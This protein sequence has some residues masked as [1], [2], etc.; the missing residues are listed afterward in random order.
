MKLLTH[1]MIT[2]SLL[3]LV[4][5]GAQKT[6]TTL[7]VSSG[8][9]IS[10][11]TYPG[12][13]VF[14]GNSTTGQKFSV[15]VGMIA[16]GANNQVEVVLDKGI[17]SFGA[18]GWA[19]GN[20]M[21]GVAEC[22]VLPSVN[23]DT[24][25]KV[26]N[27]DLNPTDCSLS[28]FGENLTGTTGLFKPLRLVTCGSFYT[29][30]STGLVLSSNDETFC[31]SN[32]NLA[33]DFKLHAKFARITVPAIIPGQTPGASPLTICVPLTDGK[34]VTA[35]T[36]PAKGLP[37][38]IELLESDC[39]D[40]N[41]KLMSS[42]TLLKGINATYSGFDHQ[43][44]PG[45]TPADDSTLYLL[46]TIS[47]RGISSLMSSLP[48]FKCDYANPLKPCIKIPSTTFDRYVQ[49]NQDIYIKDQAAGESCTDLGS[50]GSLDLNTADILSSVGTQVHCR[51]DNGK[52]FVRIDKSLFGTAGCTVSCNL[53]IN[54]GVSTT[55]LSVKVA[56][57][58]DLDAHNLVYRT[59]GFEN[60]L[61]P[62]PASPLVADQNNAIR[63]LESLTGK[64]DDLRQFGL[65]S[66]IREMFSPDAIG[67]LFWNLSATQM[68]NST[69]NVSFWED[70][71]Q[72]SYQVKSVAATSI[73]A[74]KIPPYLVSNLIPGTTSSASYFTHIITISRILG[75]LLRLEQIIRYKS[76]QQLGML[77][78]YDKET[79]SGLTRSQR[80]LV[81]WNTEG[82]NFDRVESYSTETEI[83]SS[84]QVEQIRSSFIR[85][86]R[87]GVAF[88]AGLPVVG[89][90]ARIEEYSFESRRNTTNSMYDEW[91]SRS[92]V[93]LKDDKAVFKRQVF[94]I[95]NAASSL[96]YFTD[97]MNK[98]YR[99]A[100]GFSEDTATV[101]SPNGDY[102]L[103]A[104][105]ALNTTSTNNLRVLI[106]QAGMI[107]NSYTFPVA[108]NAAFAPKAIIDNL[109]IAMVGFVAYDGTNYNLFALRFDGA[110]WIRY[111]GI[112]TPANYN[113]GWISSHATIPPEF[114]LI[115]RGT[116]KTIV[117]VNGSSNMNSINHNGTTWQSSNNLGTYTQASKIK[118][119]QIGSNYFISF[120][121][122][123]VPQK[124]GLLKTANFAPSPI[125]LGSKAATSAVAVYT[126][127]N[128][129]NADLVI[130][131]SNNNLEKYSSLTNAA[132]LNTASVTTLSNYKKYSPAPHCFTRS[133]TTSQSLGATGVTDCGVPDTS[134]ADAVKS[135]Q[136]KFDIESL[137][138]SNLNGVFTIPSY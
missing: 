59:V 30:S 85:A 107:K 56:P 111:D 134:H 73:E 121:F 46:S 99:K 45:G 62:D 18:V 69:V 53:S 114:A 135:S 84:S 115:D 124:V 8:M 50:V 76:G 23:I 90:N 77:E 86:E 98:D 74:N 112:T 125:N 22:A 127:P 51:D 52:L 2:T 120:I 68:L 72:K 95:D 49:P 29:N 92:L 108:A 129:A 44:Y 37:L 26:I 54:F 78:S 12:G 9:A 93:L 13:L 122:Q 55:T 42:Y 81:Y 11:N 71:A 80:R 131:N 118:I 14:Y 91:G 36:L 10:N 70:G 61:Y 43:Y 128:G 82:M 28:H 130:V 20:L 27:L 137:K 32:Q 64:D 19:G 113:S 66:N 63:S 15:P 39:A 117:Y 83:N 48:R 136:F 67:G 58:P 104:W 110:D 47:R 105:S 4:S 102:T 100:S 116:D 16:G 21:E 88:A 65:L 57:F 79:D 106:K 109:G 17:W 1:L 34:V 60:I 24:N 101:K 38:S 25:D 97:S 103:T 6:T 35:K 87:D 132:D 123:P 5:C 33:P 138:P 89:A 126:V 119:N 31:T 40:A 3:V 94:G 7:Q 75:G 133:T 96:D 41:K